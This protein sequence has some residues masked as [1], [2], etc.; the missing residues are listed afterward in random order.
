L[1]AGPDS[2]DELM[3]T[4]RALGYLWAAP[5]TVAFGLT[6]G[7]LTL[8]TGGK[9]QVRRG[10]LEFHGGFSTWLSH[11]GK[12]AAM[13]LGHV[14]VGRDPWALDYCRDH[15]HAHVRQVEHWGAA[16]VPAYLAASAI[17]WARGRH[18]YLDNWFEIQARRACGDEDPRGP[19]SASRV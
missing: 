11:R 9:V 15:E 18:F 8:C 5:T 2:N 12:F 14:I 6:A 13:T 3:K 7:V 16:F 17:A 4:T 19:K 1:N 10:A